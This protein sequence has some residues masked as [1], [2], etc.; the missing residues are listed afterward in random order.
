MVNL[1]L[2]LKP[3]IQLLLYS[4]DD[5]CNMT[6]IIFKANASIRNEKSDTIP[7]NGNTLS[8]T[9]SLSNL[10][11]IN[12]NGNITEDISYKFIRQAY[13]TLLEN[14]HDKILWVETINN[15]MVIVLGVILD[16]YGL[17]IHLM[18]SKIIHSSDTL[19]LND[20]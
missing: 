18:I 12:G 3:K 11:W 6:A 13:V 1:L 19:H 7:Q 14:S 4:S 8:E 10:G 15:D 9:L 20:L 2:S 17:R 5:F 16:K